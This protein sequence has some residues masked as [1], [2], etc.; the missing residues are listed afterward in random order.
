MDTGNEERRLLDELAHIESER[1]RRLQDAANITNYPE[2]ADQEEYWRGFVNKECDKKVFVIREKLESTQRITDATSRGRKQ[3]RDS[4]ENN[5]QTIGE[6]DESESDELEQ[7]PSLRGNDLGVV[8]GGFSSDENSLQ[9]DS[10]K[11]RRRIQDDVDVDADSLDG[12]EEERLLSQVEN[13]PIEEIVPD[14]EHDDI[15]DE[16]STEDD[17]DLESYE[18]QLEIQ[19]L[20]K[21]KLMM[22]I[23]GFRSKEMRRADDADNVTNTERPTEPAATTIST[24]SIDFNGKMFHK[25]VCYH[26]SETINGAEIDS[27]VGIL[28]FFSGHLA[29][30]VLIVPFEETILGMEDNGYIADYKPSTHVQVYEDLPPLPLANFVM[31]S[32]DV[33][34][35]PSLIYEP[36]T[37]GNWQKFGYFMDKPNGKRCGRRDDFR[38]LDL[39]AGCGGMHLGFKN[40]GFK[41]VKAVENNTWALDTLTSNG[42]VPVFPGSVNDYLRYYEKNRTRLGRIPCLHVSPPCQGFSAANRLGGIND[43]ENN[44]LSMAF[45]EAV[46]IVEPIVAIFENVLGMWRRQHIRYLKNIVKELLK[47]GYQVRCARLQACDY[48]DP[49]KRARLFLVATHRSTPPPRIPPKSHGDDPDLLPYV[50][51]KDALAGL[52]GCHPNM[53]GASTSVRPGQ[54]GLV[55]L[56]PDGLA[57][58]VRGRSVPPFHHEEDR[59]INVREAA[60]LQSFPKDYEFSGPLHEQYRQVGNAVPIELATAVAQSARHLL[61]YKYDGE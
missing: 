10:R 24:E 60:T 18:A 38:V 6:T 58:A 22:V 13:G 3:K 55:R 50:T 43:L 36:Q 26:Y 16:D 57:P 14:S 20:Q 42:S 51:V 21:S 61:V 25:G 44:E 54:H 39:F 7:D 33:R 32:R 12:P 11:K 47:L 17:L 9:E 23:Q 52:Q 40:A 4:D 8:N 37:P 34:N 35:I 45:V 28:G 2:L 1:Q 19:E 15:I 27:I 46:R 30:C 29:K 48:G 31:E 56:E 53:E 59:C 5:T 49:Q 41:T